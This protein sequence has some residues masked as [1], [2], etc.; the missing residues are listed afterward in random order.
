MAST[1]KAVAT[2]LCSVPPAAGG[3]LAKM[4]GRGT[5]P[6]AGMVSPMKTGVSPMK[7]VASPGS[8]GE[9]PLVRNPPSPAAPR[10]APTSVGSSPMKA[11]PAEA[12]E[13]RTPGEKSKSTGKTAASAASAVAAP[14][15]KAKAKAKSA[16]KGAA[17]VA[18]AA[19]AGDMLPPKAVAP[20]GKKRNNKKAQLAEQQGAEPV[21]QND[22]VRVPRPKL[23]PKLTEDN[24]EISDREESSDEIP[25]EL[26]R[27]EKHVPAWVD[28]F[29]QKAI[30]QSDWEPDSI[31]GRGVPACDLD[32][33]FPDNLYRKLHKTKVKRVRG[34]SC[35]WGPDRLNGK[36]IQVYAQK[37]GQRKR[38]SMFQRHSLASRSAKSKRLHG[39]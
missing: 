30:E 19:P 32:E 12:A 35:R 26:D 39:A 22:T 20:K 7:M 8:C 29:E 33:I 9:S 15:G 17:A 31:F 36:E 21:L 27:S 37:M 23:P 10:V 34:S 2:S 18:T 3:L 24:Y 14:K 38:L 11:S 4:A 5:L 1:I 6:S 13:P 16:G 25:L 28:V